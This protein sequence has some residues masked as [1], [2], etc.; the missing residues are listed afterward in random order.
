MGKSSAFLAKTEEE[1]QEGTGSQHINDLFWSTP[2]SVT[3][4]TTGQ[5]A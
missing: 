2:T 3:S 5:P 4:A 1:L